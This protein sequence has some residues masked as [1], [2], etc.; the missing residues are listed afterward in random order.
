MVF[1]NFII[2]LARV[3]HLV[4]SLMVWLIIGRALISWFSPDPYNPL[5]QFLFR[6]T[7]PVLSPIRNV[8]PY[9]GGIDLSPIV[10]LL[11]IEFFKS[12]IVSLL[13]DIANKGLSW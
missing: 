9:F 3:I 7:E 10:V 12:F 2:A 5:V 4:L 6:V 11:A 8:L 1:E 13:Y